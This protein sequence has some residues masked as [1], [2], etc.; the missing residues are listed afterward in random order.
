MP[1]RRPPLTVEQIL[2]WADAHHTRTGTWPTAWSGSV[3]NAPGE[4]W[5]ALDQSL[6]HGRRGLPRGGSLARLLA[7]HRRQ[8]R[9][10]WVPW[11]P[12][13]DELLRALPPEE[14]ARR[15]GR[16]LRA[17]YRRRHQLGLPGLRTGPRPRA[18]T[19]KED[20][21]VRALPAAAVAQRTGRSLSAVYARRREL[22]M[23]R[24]YRG[25]GTG[26]DGG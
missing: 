18:W 26:A 8:H 22:G 2:A 6:Y 5:G 15:T 3:A 10:G 12:E 21:L 1:R 17:V 11:R 7:R 16:S 20:K 13:E 25:Q 4:T 14:A 23:G 24:R 19:G 9:P